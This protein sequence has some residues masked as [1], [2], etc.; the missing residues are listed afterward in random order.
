MTEKYSPQKHEFGTDA[1]TEYAKSITPGQ[2]KKEKKMKKMKDFF[3]FVDELN[4]AVDFKNPGLKDGQWY[5]GDPSW[6]DYGIEVKNKKVL[7]LVPHAGVVE[8]DYQVREGLMERL[9][10]KSEWSEIKKNPKAVAHLNN[11]LKKQPKY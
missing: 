7:P 9:R 2:G 8:S 1:A 4:E 10:N 3:E 6:F 11:R 5:C